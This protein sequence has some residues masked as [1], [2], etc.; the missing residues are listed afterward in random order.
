[1]GLEEPPFAATG[2]DVEHRDG[3]GIAVAVGSNV[4]TDTVAASKMMGDREV[5][6]ATESSRLQLG[7]LES[8][9]AA[10]APVDPCSLRTDV[11]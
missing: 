4:E 5:V 3:A 11:G 8:A 2:T 6:V 7:L 9:G 1:M 10:P